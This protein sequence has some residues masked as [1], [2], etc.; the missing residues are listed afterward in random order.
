MNNALIIARKEFRGLFQS[1]VAVIFLGVFLAATLTGFFTWQTFFARGLADIRPLFELLPLLLIL[2]VAA[3]TMRAWA[4]ERRAGTLEVLLTLPVHTRD[5]VLGKFLAGL[6]LVGVALT[7]TLPIPVIVSTLGPLDW[8][9]VLGGY[10]GAT[11]LAS[12][13]LAIGLCV[14]SRT[15]N[16][17]V[18]LISTLVV[19]LGLYFIG[20]D[21]FTAFFSQSTGELLRAFGT[22]SR[23]HSIER[24]VLDLRDIMYYASLTS[25]FLVLNAVFLNRQRIDPGSGAGKA[26]AGQWTLLVALTFA[27]AIALNAW[28]FPVHQARVDMTS[29]GDFSLHQSTKATLRELNEPLRIQGVFSDRTHPLLSPLVPQ[30]RDLL[31]EYQVHGAGKVEV[32]FVDPSTDEELQ[33]ELGEQFAVRPFPFPVS[34]RSSQSIINAYFSVIIQ[35]GDQYEV[36]NFPD[37]I[38]VQA[39]DM[40]LDVALRNP[41]YDLTRT[42]KKLSQEFQSLEVVFAQLPEQATLTA[43]ITPNQVPEDLAELTGLMRKVGEEMERSARGKLVFSEQDP[44]QDPA[45]ADRLYQ[46]YGLRPIPLDLLGQRSF[47]LHLVLQIGDE[48][49]YVM[50]RAELTEADL[51]QAIEAAVKRATPGQFTTVAVYTE[52]PEAPPPNPQIPPQFQP[53]PPQPDY[54]GLQQIFGTEYDVRPTQLEGGYLAEDID[55]LVIGKAGV[56]SPSQQFAV[57]QFLMRGGSVVAMAGAHR[58]GAGQ[59]GLSL[60]K[61]A[62][63]LSAMLSAWG[64]TV[65]EGLVLDPQHATFPMPTMKRLGG[66]P[67]RTV[68][69]R[70]YPPFPFIQTDGFDREHPAVSSLSSVT[71]PWSSPLTLSETLPEAMEVHTILQ[72]SSG[73]WV[74]T[75]GSIDP[76]YQTYPTY[77]FPP[78]T[79]TGRQ[80]VAVSLEGRFSSYFADKPNPTFTAS[81]GDDG[82]GRILKE[83]VADGRLVVLGSSEMVS[84]I[85]LQLARDPSGTGASH[86]SNLQLVQNLID[87]SVEDSDLLAIRGGGA[88]TRTLAPLDDEAKGTIELLSYGLVFGPMLLL[89]LFP[90]TRRYRTQPIPL[91]EEAA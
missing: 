6:G 65:E 74:D 9:P 37:L 8:G 15:D 64:V 48:V 41:E 56:L 29:N 62:L 17:V 42:I 34:D 75:S 58:I 3:V 54:R 45:T 2:L 44:T 1:S 46:D 66:M 16:Q 77:G 88:F 35:Y 81:G 61:E 31:T 12:T 69:M 80:T 68:E 32:M 85:L 76:N 79:E 59:Q 28:L 47:Y 10:I 52:Q 70:P 20:D 24:G 51:K 26:R 71:M 33:G 72:T 23:F 83:S 7:L 43:Y 13:Y 82:S 86:R 22:G 30:V 67:I 78:P 53:P 4:E 57:D 40:D 60:S 73:S 50:P 49:Q 11:L 21:R 63:S 89:V 18:A 38:E 91:P 5:L 55:V 27:N 84:D 36:L 90:R 87:W 14:S 39:D 25:L 19:G